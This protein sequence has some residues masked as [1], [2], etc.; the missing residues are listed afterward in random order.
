MRWI[1][2]FTLE[3]LRAVST[4]RTKLQ[5]SIGDTGAKKCTAIPLVASATDRRIVARLTM[6]CTL[7]LTGAAYYVFNRDVF[8]K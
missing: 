7:P 5:V 3:Q 8:L 4:N 6:Y 2:A 1:S